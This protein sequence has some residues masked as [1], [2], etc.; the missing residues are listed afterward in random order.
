[1]SGESGVPTML[2]VLATL[3]GVAAALYYPFNEVTG[4]M[5]EVFHLP[6]AREFC[7]VCV[8]T[9]SV[10]VPFLGDVSGGWR[11]LLAWNRGFICSPV[12]APCSASI[13]T[14]RCRAL[15]GIR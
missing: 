5:D 12:C 13:G 1:M 10:F 14:Q 11:G 9:L 8:L 2:A 4:Y 3:A 15:S 6:Q 7:R